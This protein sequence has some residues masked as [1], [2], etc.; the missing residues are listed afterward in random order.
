M[1]DGPGSDPPAKYDRHRVVAWMAAY[2]ILAILPMVIALLGP[3]PAPRPFFVEFGVGLGFLGISILALQFVTS[4]RFR[5]IAPVFGADVVLQFHRQAGV[6]AL[7]LVL[8]HPIVLVATDPEY[9]EF[10]DPRVN[11]LRA[12]ALSA[13]IPATILLI[14]TSLWREQVGLNYE[15]WRVVHGVLSLA[16]VFI[17]MVHGIQ[18]GH[19]LDDWWRQGLWIG[20]LSGAMYLVVH[21]RIV[22]PLLMRRHPYRVASVRAETD[23]V[24]TLVLE[25]DGGDRLPFR[26]GQFAWITLG[27]SPFSLQQH[28]FSFSSGEGDPTVE[29]TAKELGDFTSTWSE[30]APGTRAFLEGPYGGFTL[31]RSAAGIV[32]LVGGIGVTPAMSMIRTLSD[33]RDRRPVILFYGIDSCDGVVF[34]D[35]IRE[36]AAGELDLRVVF[37]PENPPDDWSGPSGFID[38]EVLEEH[39]SDD[40]LAYEFFICGPEPLMDTVETT[41]RGFGVP[42]RRIY[43]ERFQI[44]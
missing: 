24:N 8:A 19:Y 22:R 44:V 39:L 32:F 4:G 25:A 42:W 23:D 35:E 10:F 38:E 9:L 26:A 20:M 15:W 13:V 31:D 29:F 18:V 12:L 1:S 14:V 11:L 6:L 27:D 17:G 33:T 21:S 30:V 28:P 16:V 2:S 43:T 5:R 40:E 37:V 34:G 7:A 41:L 36:I 3:L